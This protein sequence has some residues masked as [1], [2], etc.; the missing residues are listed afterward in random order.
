MLYTDQQL[1]PQDRSFADE[2]NGY[3]PCFGVALSPE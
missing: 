1:F 3:M 2:V